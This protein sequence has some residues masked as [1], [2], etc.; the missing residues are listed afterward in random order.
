[1]Q[2]RYGSF[3]ERVRLPRG[4]DREAMRAEYEDGLLVV[5]MP[6]AKP[7]GEKRRKIAIS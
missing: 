4:V 1:M 2:A 5:T 3:C 6:R 7:E